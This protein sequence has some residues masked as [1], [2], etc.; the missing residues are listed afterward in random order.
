M[1]AD[2]I[3]IVHDPEEGAWRLRVRW[4]SYLRPRK[5]VN[6]Q[7]KNFIE[8]MFLFNDF[9]YGY[10]AVSFASDANVKNKDGVKLNQEDIKRLLHDDIFKVFNEPHGWY[11]TPSKGALKV[12]FTSAMDPCNYTVDESYSCVVSPHYSG[13]NPKGDL[14]KLWYCGSQ[15]H[16][17]Q[18]PQNTKQFYETAKK[19]LPFAAAQLEFEWDRAST[20]SMM[21]TATF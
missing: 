17:L 9:D 21:E 14:V 3:K 7:P 5:G 6:Y 10:T 18:P 15:T 13:F 19:H 20:T 11:T 4:F 2:V 1:I 16:Y 12:R 8:H